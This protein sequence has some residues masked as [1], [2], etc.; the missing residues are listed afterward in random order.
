MRLAR[1]VMPCMG[2]GG[3]DIAGEGMHGWMAWGNRTDGCR[4]I[5]I[6]TSFKRENVFKSWN[7]CFRFRA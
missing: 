2:R 5:V 3:R 7:I 4:C 1:A 6:K